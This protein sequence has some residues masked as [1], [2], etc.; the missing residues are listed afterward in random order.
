MN[1][2]KENWNKILGW[3]VTLFILFL[4]VAA[5]FGWIDTH[6]ICYYDRWGELI[7]CPTNELLP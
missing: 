2:L 7:D 4:I 3:S 5:V 1:W 6:R